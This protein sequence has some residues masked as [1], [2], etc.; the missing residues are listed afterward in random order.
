MAVKVEN[1]GNMSEAAI[2]LLP[3]K[4]AEGGGYGIT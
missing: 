1:G 4:A 3:Q 2:V